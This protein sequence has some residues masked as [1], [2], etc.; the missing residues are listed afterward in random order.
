MA[1]SKTKKDTKD[2]KI[3]E[4]LN[5]DTTMLDNLN[6]LDGLEDIKTTSSEKEEKVLNIPEVRKVT[7]SSINKEDKN[8]VAVYP[9]TDE[10][11]KILYEVLRRRGSGQP[12]ILRSY[13][14]DGNKIYKLQDNTKLTPYN[15]P[16]VLQGIAD[17]KI[18]WITEGESK[19][20]KLNEIGF[21]GTTC[22]FKGPEKW[23]ENYSEF[24]K[25]AKS[26]VIIQDNDFNGE[27]FAENTLESIMNVLDN[28]EVAILK[29]SDI[30]SSL[31]EGGDIED[32][33]KIAGFENVKL[34]LETYA[35]NFI[36][37]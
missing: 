14:E 1:D 21:V 15:L 34:T 4:D 32:L 29:L 13:D 2:E 26:I 35:S 10:N 6:I 37:E 36:A 9:Y 17:G 25:G 3:M 27:R 33:I 12:Y 22:A 24:L 18:I 31:K 28:V 5:L 20:D 7:S 30:C 11:G 8:T 23:G 19:A 16:N